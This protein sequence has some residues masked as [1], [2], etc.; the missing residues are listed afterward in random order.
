MISKILNLITPYKRTFI[1]IED[2]ENGIAMV[3]PSKRNSS[4]YLMKDDVFYITS[5]EEVDKLVYIDYQLIDERSTE[6][7]LKQSFERFKSN[8]EV[9]FGKTTEPY[10]FKIIKKL[11]Y[12]DSINIICQQEI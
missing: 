4:I 3:L 12:S 7:H 1:S 10:K 9:H 6:V 5:Y 8:V 2:H 11:V